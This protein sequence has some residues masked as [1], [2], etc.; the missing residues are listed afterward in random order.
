[1]TGVQTCALPICKAAKRPRSGP[2]ASGAVP[3]RPT[4]DQIQSGDELPALERTTGFAH[5][6]RYAAVNDE[7]IDVHMERE[8]AQAAGQPDVFGMGNLRIAYAHNAIHDWLA[9]SGFLPIDLEQIF[10]RTNGN[11]TVTELAGDL[12]AGHVHETLQVAPHTGHH[13]GGRPV[14]RGHGQRA[15]SP[16]DGLSRPR[17]RSHEGRH[18]ATLRQRLHQSS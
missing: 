1:M 10:I 3:D 9:G 18:G 14:H 2:K 6:N 13:D 7:F 8:A 15:T 12:L 11:V 5:W 16:G 17:L 4:F